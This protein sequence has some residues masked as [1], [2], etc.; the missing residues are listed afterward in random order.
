M[1]STDREYA[2]HTRAIAQRSR[3][4]LRQ[5]RCSCGAAAVEITVDR[6]VTP[7]TVVGKCSK[8]REARTLTV[9]EARLKL[10]LIQEAR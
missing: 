10:D 8:H 9:A 6:R 7:P 1:T 2:A 5:R 3:E 4:D